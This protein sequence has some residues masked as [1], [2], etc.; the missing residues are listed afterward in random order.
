MSRALIGARKVWCQKRNPDD[1]KIFFQKNLFY[2]HP[3]SVSIFFFFTGCLQHADFYARRLR[4]LEKKK[5]YF[6]T[7]FFFGSQLQH[8]RKKHVMQELSGQII[9]GIQIHEHNN[10]KKI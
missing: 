2:W 7:S 10:K 6:Y 3:I 5:L 4:I 1:E 9:I 8:R